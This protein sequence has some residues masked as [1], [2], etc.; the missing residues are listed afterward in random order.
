MANTDSSTVGIS[1]NVS[2]LSK[3]AEEAANIKQIQEIAKK[4]KAHAEHLT[5]V[6]HDNANPHPAYVALIFA[7]VLG[8]IWLLYIIFIKPNISGVWMDTSG[9]KWIVE[10]SFSDV[11]VKVVTNNRV[12][13]GKAKLTDNIFKFKKYVGVWNYDDVVIFLGGGG[14]E[15]VKLY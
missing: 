1:S 9:N 13:R 15:R 6:V 5:E 12:I 11:D 10:Q 8:V 3:E 7:L 14:M 2:A 4:N